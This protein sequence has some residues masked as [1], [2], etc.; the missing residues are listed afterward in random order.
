MEE[1]VLD[2]NAAAGVLEALFRFEVTSAR[3]VCAGCGAAEEVGALT[4]YLDAPGVVLRCAHCTA[5]LIRV[6]H[7][8][9]RYWFEMQGTLCL[10]VREPSGER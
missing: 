4:A 2:G 6:V 10:E 7:G 1:R 9:G 5:V 3:A 8:G